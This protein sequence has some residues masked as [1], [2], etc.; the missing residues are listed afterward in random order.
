MV[1]DADLG[2]YDIFAAPW[3]TLQG[4]QCDAEGAIAVGNAVLCSDVSIACQGIRD[5]EVGYRQYYFT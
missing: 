4:I 2:L 1:A 3:Q 5:F